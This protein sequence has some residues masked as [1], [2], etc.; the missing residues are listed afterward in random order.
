M[1]P[2][3]TRRYFEE[4]NEQRKGRAPGS[5][6]FEALIRSKIGGRFQGLTGPKTMAKAELIGKP[7]DRIYGQYAGVNFGPRSTLKGIKEELL[8]RGGAWTSSLPNQV[9]NLPE[10][11]TIF[12]MGRQANPNVWSHEFRHENVNNSRYFDGE[13]ANR[14]FDVLYGSTSLPAYKSNV[15]QAYRYIVENSN[16][17]KKLPFEEREALRAVSLKDQED[18]VLNRL[19]G[20]LG[21]QDLKRE[22]VSTSSR[23]LNAIKNT[24][25]KD[26]FKRTKDL[27]QSVRRTEDLPSEAIEL[28]S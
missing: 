24:F 11:K 8:G 3:N 5:P 6:E 7:E 9:P 20:L 28:R 15:E 27:N 18:F 13:V 19:K 14:L 23:M 16:D 22:N 21:E 10:G 2:R 26:L 17:Y 4:L 12:G 1:P 25:G